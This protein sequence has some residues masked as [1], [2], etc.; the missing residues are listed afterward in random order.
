MVTDIWVFSDR[1]VA[2]DVT[3]FDVQATDGRV[4]KV[5]RSRGER[6][7]QHL[8]VDAQP[9]LPGGRRLIIP[10]GLIDS[11]DTNARR[12]NVDRSRDELRNAP[13]YDDAR[14]VD[15]AYRAD[16]DTYFAPSRAEPRRERQTRSQGASR[17]RSQARSQRRTGSRS[18][19]AR[20]RT[21]EGPT[22]AELYEQAKRLDVKGRSKMSK[23]ELARAVGRARG[24]RQS[25]GARGGRSRQR[26]NPVDVQAFLE[27]V[28]YP[29]EKGELLRQAR[30][31]GASEKVRSTIQRLPD[32]RFKDPTAVSE[33]IGNTR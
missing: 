33:A 16:V 14:G 29:A 7:L 23:A 24:G 18:R 26:A 28:K 20:R 31:E 3:G 4:G 10:A 19:T 22:K 25:S 30:R 17:G 1:V 9:S 6:G 8:A 21:Q 13:A 12:V 32:K 15:L 5:E 11:V 2:L 27:G